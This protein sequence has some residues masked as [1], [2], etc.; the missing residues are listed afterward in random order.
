MS[1]VVPIELTELGEPVEV[2]LT[3]DQARLLAAS[4]VVSAVPV[5]DRPGRWLVGAAG[6]VGAARIGSVEVFIRPEG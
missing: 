2:P 4:G 1:A 3:T 5:L 6:K